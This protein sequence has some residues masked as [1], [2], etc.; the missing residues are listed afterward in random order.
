MHRRT[1]VLALTALSLAACGGGTG[2]G[3]GRTTNAGDTANCPGEAVDVV[4]SVAQWGQIAEELVGDCGTV[5]TIVASSAVDP[6]DFEPSTGDLAAFSEAD[7]VV[8]NGADYD[9]WAES[10]VET[11]DSGP[12]VVSAAEVA[13]LETGEHADDHA[14]DAGHAATD[15][16]L[17][18]DPEIVPGTAAAITDALTE[19]SPDAADHFAQRAR[20]WAADLEPY[21]AL[22]AGLQ[23]SAS[24]RTYAATET[25]FDRM[26]A[27]VGLTDATPE[28]YRRAASNESEPAPGDLAEFEAA[29]ADGGVDVLVFNSQTSGGIPEQLRAAA[30]DAGVPVVEVTESPVDLD[31]SFV[32]WQSAQLS[33]LSDALSRTP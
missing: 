1:V 30:E 13:G 16:H 19:L 27:A 18:Y 10:A 4:A 9:G 24:G 20:A 32:A 26:A 14:D 31:G 8:V 5:T 11:L 6:H 2:S 25:V 23:E 28:G 3:D 22:V 17:W 21:T 12:V 29:L 33:A 15:P 7:L